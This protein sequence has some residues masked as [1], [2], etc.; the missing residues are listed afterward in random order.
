M[1]LSKFAR[2]T[3][4]INKTCGVVEAQTKNKAAAATCRGLRKISTG[5]H[6]YNKWYA[7]LIAKELSRR[8][9]LVRSFSSNGESY[10]FKAETKKL[11][12]IV[13]HSL[14][15]DKEVFIRELISNSSDALEKRRFTQTASIRSVDD[16]V[17]NE[18]GEIPLHIKVSADAKKNLFI[19][20]DSGI[21]MNKEEV[22]E[23]L[24]TIAKSGSLNFLNALKERSR[25]AT[26]ES[27]N[28]SD[29]SG[30][31]SEI[32]QPGDNIIGQF[33]VGFYSSFVVS[34][35]VEVFTRSHDANSVGYHWKS[36]G[37]GTFTL[38]EVEDLPRGTKIVC[39]LKESCKEFSNIHRVQEI[40]EKFSSFI[41]FPVYIVNRKKDVKGSSRLV[42]GDDMQNE[43]SS[44]LPQEGLHK[45]VEKEKAMDG[46]TEVED[47]TTAADTSKGETESLTDE[48]QINN[49][50]PLWCKE[51]V[52]EEEH[53]K[54]FKF[55]TKN[56]NY[57]DDKGY[58][59][60][61]LYKTDAPMS[62]KSV[63]YIPEEAPSR[64][65]Q[66]SNE[67][68]V[69]LYCKKV[70]VKKNADN[71]IPKWLHFV[72]GV[73]DCEDMP[74]NISRENMQDSTL[75]NKISRVVVTKILKTLEKESTNDEDKYRKFYTNYSYYLKEGV[76]ED[77]S[78]NFY[79]NTLMNLLRFYSIEQRKN[80]SLK[81]YVANFKNSQK[82]IYYFCVNELNVALSSPYME[83]FKKQGVDV[84]LLFEEIDE[85]VLMNLQ[86]FNGAKFVSIDSSQNEDFDQ[87]LL[88]SNRADGAKAGDKDEASDEA[89]KNG[90][91][92]DSQKS[93]LA[94]YFKD[95]LGS[96]CSDVKFS[97]RLTES[98][99]VVTG[100]L[101]PTLRKVMKATM[102]N[103]SFQDNNMLNNLP[104]TL[105]L[106][107]SHTI[108]TS[109]FHLKNTNQDVAKLLVQQL[110]DNAC[111]AAG[112]LE[113]PRSLLT[114]LN[115]LLLLTA[116]YAYH[117]EKNADGVSGVQE[118]PSPSEPSAGN[119]DRTIPATEASPAQAD[120]EENSAK[121]AHASKL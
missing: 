19:I 33:G 28:S 98:P 116:R 70:L 109:I 62:I 57:G 67:I 120:D 13:A 91:F 22:I 47:S 60:K 49:Q 44:S 24:G 35:E 87:E 25:N 92:N 78:N 53:N 73:I 76:L 75:I 117:Y 30:E 52:T 65:F 102:K 81:D 37:N 55:L 94:K 15:T 32:S 93:E 39:H 100:F 42:K 85:F 1:S 90:I 113:D 46:T 95:V 40:V 115:E 64:L 50:K 111:I 74:L 80:I 101:S 3:L 26:E 18:A 72:K 106:N 66:Q 5:S 38:K 10:E 104:A 63:F 96:K 58:V 89:R 69:S 17:A 8:G 121:E 41:N 112:I 23:N 103:S 48:V 77:S 79:K 59:Y 6:V 11:L 29:P 107:P 20:E 84:L 45:D 105:E 86:E 118:D 110:Y 34:D 56:K 108:V 14:Y 83:P 16:T 97:D 54:F 68:E 36:D 99:A 9:G 2:S 27:K 51:N 114:K 12:Q 71:I 31:K 4:Q 43:E 119:V 7:Q 82:K 61:V 88:N 21:G